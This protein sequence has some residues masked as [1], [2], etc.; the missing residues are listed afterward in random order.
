MTDETPPASEPEVLYTI[1]ETAAFLRV[2]Y[3][4]VY[5]LADQGKIKTIHIGSKRLVPASE[6]DRLLKQGTE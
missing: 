6:I 1:R 5:R 2:Y 3:K 4:S